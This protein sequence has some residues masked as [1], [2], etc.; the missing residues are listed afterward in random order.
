M[1]SVLVQG[2]AMAPTL[3]DGDEVLVRRGGRAIR[4]GDVVVAEF[5]SRPGRIVVRRAARQV[6]G[7]W[8]LTSDNPFGGDTSE[9]LGPATVI[10]RVLFR[11]W[12]RPGQ[13]PGPPVFLS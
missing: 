6:P 7:G 4:P 5:A 3:R 10:G 8:W 9:T 11:W 2:P 12:P 13:L 1:F